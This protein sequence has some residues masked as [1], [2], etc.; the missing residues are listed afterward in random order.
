M[1]SPVSVANKELTVYLSLLESTL[2]KNIG[3]RGALLLTRFP[4]K[5]IGPKDHRGNPNSSIQRIDACDGLSSRLSSGCR[6]RDVR[7]QKQARDEQHRCD[8]I[9]RAGEMDRRQW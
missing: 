2:M 1:K 4:T 6:A 8:E 9:G 3:G 7:R 5:G